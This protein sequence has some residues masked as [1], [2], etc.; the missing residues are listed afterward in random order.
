M[1]RA[2]RAMPLPKSIRASSAIRSVT[3]SIWA[4]RSP[5]ARASI[6]DRKAI[7]ALTNAAGTKGYAFAEV[8]PRFKRNPISHTIDMG[9]EIA[10]G[11]RVYIRSEGDRSPDQCGG[12]QG[13]CLCRSPSALQAQSDQSHHRYGL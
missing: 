12:H 8:H 4:L 1:R 10:Q 2:P 3:P 6:S 9:F 5:R 13:L 11:P 7:E